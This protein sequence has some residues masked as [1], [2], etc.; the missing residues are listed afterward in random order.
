M[1]KFKH[2]IIVDGKNKQPMV[3]DE[4]GKQLVF[5]TTEDWDDEP[6]PVKMYTIAK[7]RKLIKQT[8][9]NREVWKMSPRTY[10]IMPFQIGV[11]FKYWNSTNI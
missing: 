3:W 4:V 7:A 10:K 2:V 1:A 11:N 8:I 6:V 5:C 9:E